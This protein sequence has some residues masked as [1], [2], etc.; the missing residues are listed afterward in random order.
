MRREF[1]DA[2]VEIAERDERVV[3]LTGDLGFAA[4]EPFFERFPDR[5]FNAGVA[6]QNMVGMAT[7]LAEAGFTPYVYSISTFASMRGYEFIRNGPV[8]H[9]LPVRV[10]GIGEGADYSH[11]GITHY[12]LEDVALMRAQPNLTVVNPA[13]SG[14]VRPMLNAVHETTG[15]AYI[16]LSKVSQSVP[17]LPDAFALGRAHQIGHGQD[18]AIIALGAMAAN[19]VVCADLLAEQLVQARVIAVTSVSPAPID[20]LVCA[21]APV[22]LALSVEAH[23]ATGGVGSLVAEVIAE[24]EVSCRLIRAGVTSAPVGVAGSLGYMQEQLGISPGRLADRVLEAL[25][26]RSGNQATIL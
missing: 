13:S 15:P 2:L 17:G 19:A 23:Y 10:V 1:V 5:F 3:L 8:L 9:N 4:L 25:Q 21:L 6:E 18:V 7:G 24:R 12:A 26:A 11:N 20:D 16:R 22:D 14:Q